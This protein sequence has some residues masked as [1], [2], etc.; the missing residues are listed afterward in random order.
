MSLTSWAR[1]LFTRPATRTVRRGVRHTFPLR[2]EPLE[3]RL[4]PAFDLLITFGLGAT[5]NVST[6]TVAGTTRANASNLAPPIR[7]WARW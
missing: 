5:T 3:D 4:V 6:T 1:Q 2:L 7:D